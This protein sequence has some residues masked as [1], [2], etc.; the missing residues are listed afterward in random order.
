MHCSSESSL[1]AAQEKYCSTE[2]PRA[3]SRCSGL[4]QFN[5]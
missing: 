2:G 5:R 4:H 3:S 1:R